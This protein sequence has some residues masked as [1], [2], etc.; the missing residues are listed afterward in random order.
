MVG[1]KDDYCI[2][3]QSQ[4]FQCFQNLSESTVY[5]GHRSKVV[6][7]GFRFFHIQIYVWANQQ[8]VQRLI[9]IK[10][11]VLF[12]TIVQRTVWAMRRV[13]SHHDEEWLLRITHVSF[14]LEIRNNF[15]RLME[16]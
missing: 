1:S 11:E 10:I 7:D 12:F 3:I 13:H 4:L 6:T 16:R 9:F 8:T 5:S 15:A 2:F 14:I